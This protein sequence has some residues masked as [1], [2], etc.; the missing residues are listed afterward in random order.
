MKDIP[1][2]WVRV[3]DYDER[4]NKSEGGPGG[5]YA[6]ILAEIKKEPS[7]IRAYRDGKFWIAMR[8]DVD[9]FLQSVKDRNDTPACKLSNDAVSLDVAMSVAEMRLTLARI[10]SVLE[11]LAT[12]AEAIAT[13]PKTE[14]EPAGVWRDMSGEVMN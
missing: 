8:C 14:R 13:Q 1:E 9:T 2:G 7:P 10:E 12:A 5:D 6:K 11:R 3:A 4:E